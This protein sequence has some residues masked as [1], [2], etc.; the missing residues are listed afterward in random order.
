MAAPALAVIA[1]KAAVILLTDKRTWYVIGS[2]LAGFIMLCLLPAMVLMSMFGSVNDVDIAGAFAN[3]DRQQIIDNMIPEQREKLLYFESV[4]IA[5]EDEVKKQG[6]SA[7]PI[8]A[9][10]IY[11]SLLQG[12]EKESETF[13]A[14]YISC[15]AGADNDNQFFVNI[16]AKYGVTLTGEEQN[17]IIL[18]YTKLMERQTVPPGS[19][20]TEIAG[21]LQTAPAVTDDGGQILPPIR[22]DNWK[23]L[24]TSRY[25]YRTDPVTGEENTGHTGIDIGVPEGTDI[26]AAKAGIVLFTRAGSEGYGNFLAVNHGGGMVTLYAHC[27]ALLVSAGDEVTAETVIARSGNSGK[28]TAPHL[29]FEVIADGKPLNPLKYY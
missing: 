19:I 9:Q 8:K 15:F 25:G 2:I 20:H 11:L 27:S 14:D 24:I 6:I 16:T 21:L 1:K 22:V 26:Y 10:I 7:D 29:H 4:M 12:K 3:V 5:I 18:L 13:Y 17:E 28:S 23:S